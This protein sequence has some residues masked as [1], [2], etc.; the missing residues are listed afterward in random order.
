MKTLFHRSGRQFC[1]AVAVGRWF[2]E[3]MHFPNLRCRLTTF[4]SRNGVRVV[5]VGPVTFHI[6]KRK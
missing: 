5:H 6:N 3:V 4:I 2:I 1:A